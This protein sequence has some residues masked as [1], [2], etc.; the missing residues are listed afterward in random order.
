MTQTAC[1]FYIS[2]AFT[3][4]LIIEGVDSQFSG[5]CSKDIHNGKSMLFKDDWKCFFRPA[6]TADS[7]RLIN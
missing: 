7:I 4:R 5:T 3:L 1:G 6:E 2:V